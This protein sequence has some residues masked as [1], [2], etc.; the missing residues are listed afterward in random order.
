MFPIKGFAEATKPEKSERVPAVRLPVHR[1]RLQFTKDE[2][3][4]DQSIFVISDTFEEAEQ[5]A[6]K[7]LAGQGAR[8]VNI[9]ERQNFAYDI[10]AMTESKQRELYN[11]LKQKYEP[12]SILNTRKRLMGD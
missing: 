12:L 4:W 11:F 6:I 10:H 8:G 9:P 5:M 1:M 2:K 7:G 3:E